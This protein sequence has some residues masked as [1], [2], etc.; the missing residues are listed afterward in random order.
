MASK[1]FASPL[2]RRVPGLAARRKR[3]LLQL[4]ELQVPMALGALACLVVLRLLPTWPTLDA[5]YRPGTYLFAT[6]DALFLVAPVIA[7][8]AVRGQRVQ[9]CAR[10]AIWM[11]APWVLFV[12]LGELSGYAYLPWLTV[13]G[14]PALSLGMLAYVVYGSSGPQ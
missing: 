1:I 6:G 14:Y 8:M 11:L 7:W 4:V 5:A 9:R 12:G 10:M 13:A 2:D 3:I